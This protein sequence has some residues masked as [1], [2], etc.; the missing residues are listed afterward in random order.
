[1]L[2]INLRINLRINV[3]TSIHL[4][5]NL[6]IKFIPVINYI[7]KYNNHESKFCNLKC[8]THDSANATR[9]PKHGFWS[10]E[11]P[12]KSSSKE[13][14]IRSKTSSKA[15][16]LP[17]WSWNLQFFENSGFFNDFWIPKWSQNPRKKA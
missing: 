9:E 6:R 1:M 3:Y 11:N 10:L 2:L 16:M 15:M 5:I 14:K 17:R 13:L 12:R 4:R 7:I 8:S